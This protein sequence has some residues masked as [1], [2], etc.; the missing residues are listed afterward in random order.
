MSNKIIIT[1]IFVFLCSCEILIEP[2]P[3]SWNWGARPRPLTGVKGFPSADTDYGQG[4]RDGC[5]AAWDAVT[6][7]L[8]S[9]INHKGLDTKRLV[10]DADYGTGWEDGIEHCTYISDWNVI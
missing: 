10:N 1:I 5:G 2:M 8:L 6:K 7:G 3:K 9:D 4:F